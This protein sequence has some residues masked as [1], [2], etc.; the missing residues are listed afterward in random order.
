MAYKESVD[1]YFSYS[2]AVPA[3]IAA[4]LVTLII[5]GATAVTI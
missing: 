4:L 1:R 2:I 3:T 5:T